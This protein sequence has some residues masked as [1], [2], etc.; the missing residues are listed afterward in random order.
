MDNKINKHLIDIVKSYLLPDR[1]EFDKLKLVK[2]ID[3]EY[4]QYLMFEV[5][6]TFKNYFNEV[7]KA[8]IENCCIF[9]K[10]LK[11]WIEIK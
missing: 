7:S 3:F 5:F 6:D 9:D 8:P 11:K 10:I 1:N 4:R 2:S